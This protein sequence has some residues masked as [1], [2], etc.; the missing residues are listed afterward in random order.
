MPESNTLDNSPPNSSSEVSEETPHVDVLVDP[1][2]ES[3]IRV[4]RLVEAA[5]IAARWCGFTT[6]EI[7]IRVC[8]DA[9]IHEV[10]RRH[11][12]HDYP[13]DVISFG[14]HAHAPR[15]EGEVIVSLDS[16]HRVASTLSGWSEVDEVVLYTV[17]GVLHICGMDD[18]DTP[19]RTRMRE[20]E[21]H[22]L[23]ALGLVNISRFGADDAGATEDDAALAVPLA[24][25]TLEAN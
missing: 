15:V 12:D 4:D 2:Y 8:S 14:Y 24:A 17:H 21:R 6:G 25:V 7:G 22:I 20:A 13:T 1:P 23:T 19:A 5:R 11:L 16:A 3:R 18:T 9:S 10:N